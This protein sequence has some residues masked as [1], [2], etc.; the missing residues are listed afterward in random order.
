MTRS[1]LRVRK[2]EE[3][4]RMRVRKEDEKQDESKKGR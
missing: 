1:R 3:K 4:N 2:E